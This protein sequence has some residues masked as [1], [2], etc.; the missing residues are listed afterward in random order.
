MA[1]VHLHPGYT[2]IHS[3]H[4]SLVS[5][6]KWDAI[7]CSVVQPGHWLFRCEYVHITEE[8]LRLY[9]VT[10]T[11]LH[12]FSVSRWIHT[13]VAS[14]IWTVSPD[15][16]LF[17]SI[18]P[19]IPSTHMPLTTLCNPSPKGSYTFFCLLRFQACTCYIDIRGNKIPIHIN[20]KNIK[21]SSSPTPHP[22]S[23]WLTHST[24]F[25]S[26]RLLTSSLFLKWHSCGHC[27]SE[28]SQMA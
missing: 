2:C 20:R 7:P 10:V 15:T 19:F 12:V 26:L 6:D 24:D 11:G 27:H 25:Y 4:T 9:K 21:L 17:R 22:G 5:S 3:R 14:G 23:F 13:P 18:A 1:G 16:C 8:G 28:M